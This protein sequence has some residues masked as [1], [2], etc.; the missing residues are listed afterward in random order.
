MRRPDP[1]LRSFSPVS[2]HTFIKFLKVLSFKSKPSSLRIIL[3]MSQCFIEV[4]CNVIALCRISQGILGAMTFF[5]NILRPTCISR[6]IDRMNGNF[7]TSK[8]RW[9]FRHPLIF[10]YLCG[11]SQKSPFINPTLVL[12]LLSRRRCGVATSQGAKGNCPLEWC[13]VPLLPLPARAP[14]F[15]CCME[16]DPGERWGCIYPTSPIITSER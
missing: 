7:W 13:L 6:N 11:K 8:V 3:I 16:M 1:C 14:N 9:V 5:L 4:L 12:P 10:R 2:F 15:F